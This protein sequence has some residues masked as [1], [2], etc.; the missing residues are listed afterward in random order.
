MKAETRANIVF[1]FL[2]SESEDARLVCGSPGS[3]VGWADQQG[4]VT[5][6][7]VPG[8]STETP[9][10][11]IELYNPECLNGGRE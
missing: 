2:I 5:G 9:Q 11:S 7:E 6:N 1:H 3:D 4:P 10:F 8:M